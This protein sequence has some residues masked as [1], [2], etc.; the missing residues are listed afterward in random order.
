MLPYKVW[1]KVCAITFFVV[2][3]LYLTKNTFS[4]LNVLCQFI[5]CHEKLTHHIPE[6]I[7]VFRNNDMPLLW[8]TNSIQIQT[9]PVVLDYQY[10]ACENVLYAFG[11]LHSFCIL[12]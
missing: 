5:F 8:K 3:A 10:D 2:D 7:V 11:A 4:S 12:R 9:F 6:A 1:K